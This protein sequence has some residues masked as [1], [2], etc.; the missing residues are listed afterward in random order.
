MRGIVIFAAISIICLILVGCSMQ[1]MQPISEVEEMEEKLAETEEIE[2][3]E[4]ET[5]QIEIEYEEPVEVPAE[6]EQIVV[7]YEEPVEINET[8]EDFIPEGMDPRVR[9]IQK[10]GN[11]IKNLHYYYRE[12]YGDIGDA[13]IFKSG[14]LMRLKY[15]S[16]QSDEKDPY[17][18]IFLDLNAKRAQAVCADGI[19]CAL[20]FN[21]PF[22]ISYKRF[23]KLKTP[24]DWAIEI[25]DDAVI[26]GTSKY[27]SRTVLMLKYDYT[28]ML[29]N[30]HFK[31][32]AKIEGPGKFYS[33][34]IFKTNV[35]ERDV[36]IGG[37]L[38]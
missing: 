33:F 20:N 16:L 11:I 23:E 36:T 24:M 9:D 30:E 15:T 26:T 32:P 5:E 38:I 18:Q 1:K 7:E 17:T 25:P 6:E 28:E 35:P 37:V 4:Q 14:D 22:D 8:E 29:I 2:Q 10:Q 13:E 31:L 21:E 27:M 34:E 3:L 12:K 19:K